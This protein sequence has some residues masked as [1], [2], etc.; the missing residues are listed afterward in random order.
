MASKG[1]VRTTSLRSTSLTGGC[2]DIY[3]LEEEGG[4]RLRECRQEK[5]EEICVLHRHI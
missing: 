5:S 2:W 4:L 3:G 1:G